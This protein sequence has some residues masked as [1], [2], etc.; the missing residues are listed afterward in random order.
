MHH[1]QLTAAVRR[2]K[3]NLTVLGHTCVRVCVR[4]LNYM[5]GQVFLQPY[6]VIDKL[7]N[8]LKMHCKKMTFFVNYKNES[9][10]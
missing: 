1:N 8:L 9:I 10:P 3:P 5:C 2:L 6:R 4:T 7:C